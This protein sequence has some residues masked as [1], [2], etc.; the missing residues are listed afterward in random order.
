MTMSMTYKEDPYKKGFGPFLD[1]I[2]RMNFPTE[3]FDL[4]ELKVI[5]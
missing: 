3:T 2:H 1:N 4:S 5:S